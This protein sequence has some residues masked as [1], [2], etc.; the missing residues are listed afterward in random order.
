MSL[1][2]RAL[3]PALWGLLLLALVLAMTVGSYPVGPAELWRLV[4]NA[5]GGA[6]H[7]LPPQLEAIVMEVRAPRVAAAALAGAALAMSGA[8]MQA[9][10]R[11]PLAAPDLLGVSAG[12]AFGAV[13]GIFLG[14]PIA[15]IQA[16]AF[17]GGLVAV[18][19]VSLLAWRLRA[20]DRTLT[21]ILCGIAIG[22]LLSAGVAVI[23]V[24]ADPA[25]DLPAITFWLLGSFVSVRP[26]DAAGLALAALPAAAALWL[27]RWRVDLLLLSD[28]EVR[29]SGVRAGWLRA[30]VIA[31]CA[32][33]T[34]GAVAV[35]GII[36]WIGL[37]VPHAA[38][39]CAGAGFARALP[40]SAAMGALLLLAVDTLARSAGDGELPPGVLTALIGAPALF[41]LLARGRAR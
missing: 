27:L 34:S 26:V 14:W 31:A 4:R 15:A 39:L 9:V 5:L 13:L 2:G 41:V 29:T 20:A 11:N 35:G 38:R 28:E 8:G 30:A 25:G 17:A 37:V 24:L 7:G 16:A 23:K 10:F 36:G 18:A 12:A 22:S 40:V 3:G 1:P 19:L 33:A 21:L 6:A 32:L